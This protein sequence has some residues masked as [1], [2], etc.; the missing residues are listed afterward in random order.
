MLECGREALVTATISRNFASPVTPAA[1]RA[2]GE[3][4]DVEVSSRATLARNYFPLRHGNYKESRKSE[5]ENSSPLIND[6][7]L[8]VKQPVRKRGEKERETGRGTKIA[9]N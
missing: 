2:D 8:V 4:A 7:G 9:A 1:D 5:G 6:L 3:D